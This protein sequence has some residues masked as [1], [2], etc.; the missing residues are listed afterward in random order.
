MS[1]LADIARMACAPVW[2]LAFIGLFFV[3]PDTGFAQTVPE[4]LVYELSWTGI[5]VGMA[6]QEITDEGEMRRIVSTARSNDWLSVFFPVNDRIESTL[7]S[8]GAPFPGLTRHYRMQMSEGR[9]SRDREIDFDQAGRKA[10]YRDHRSG[11]KKDIPII[12]PVFDI[13]GS[14]YYVRFLPLEVGKSFVVTVL[15]GKDVE[16]VA[17]RVLRKEKLK[18]VLGELD[19]IVIRPMVKSQGV[20]EGKGSVH[21]WLTDDARRIPV[22]AQTKVTVG[23]VTAN[24]VGGSYG[25][26]TR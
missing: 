11:E 16:Q 15:D 12:P 6:T 1:R 2:W 26:A 10:V 18:T 23:S 24:L 8:A 7:E 22:R 25:P 4:K 17:V 3:L 14:F 19:T 20:F 5:P 13:Y 21:I 9:H